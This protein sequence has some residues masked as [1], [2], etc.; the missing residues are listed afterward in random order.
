[1]SLPW[2]EAAFEASIY[3]YFV[4]KSHRVQ[5]SPTH[6]QAQGR[7]DSRAE[8]RKDA[9][10]P[11]SELTEDSLEINGQKHEGSP[12]RDSSCEA[13]LQEM[14]RAMPHLEGMANE[15]QS[16]GEPNTSDRVNSLAVSPP[17]ALIRFRHY[18]SIC[19]EVENLRR[20]NMELHRALQQHQ[21]YAPPPPPPHHHHQHQYHHQ[22]PP[23]PQQPSYYGPSVPAQQQH[24]AGAFHHPHHH[25]GPPSHQHPGARAVT[26]VDAMT[27]HRGRYMPSPVDYRTGGPHHT[28]HKDRTLALSASPS[29][30]R[31]NPP[32][33]PQFRSMDPMDTSQHLDNGSIPGMDGSSNSLNSGKRKSPP[34]MEEQRHHGYG[35]SSARRYMMIRSPP[36]DHPSSLQQQ[37]V[38]S[39][40]GS[41]TASEFAPSPTGDM[42]A[43]AT[44]GAFSEYLQELARFKSTSG[45][46]RVPL[47]SPE[48][49][50]L[51]GR[52]VRQVRRSYKM[53]AKDSRQLLP[54]E[55]ADEV[56][57]HRLSSLRIARLEELGF[58]WQVTPTTVGWNVRY[59]QLV[60]FSKKFGHTNVSRTGEYAQLGEWI[61]S[62]RGLYR[63][64]S[65]ILQGERMT[66]LNAIGFQWKTEKAR[67]GFDEWIVDCERYCSESG[68]LLGK[69]VSYESDNVSHW[70]SLEQNLREWLI[71]Q[72][73]WYIKYSKGDKGYLTDERV[74]RLEDLG[75]V[76]SMKQQS[77]EEA[78]PGC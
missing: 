44:P 32:R 65:R 26:P 46:C 1:M 66:K 53:I 45:N 59:Q 16:A 74:K 49:P 28:S 71:R 60:E 64:K 7:P 48:G 37:V 4:W 78:E 25:H 34:S 3:H 31:R 40:T 42:E 38:A 58:E 52:W 57:P 72:Q 77:E 27:H 23:P 18:P 8:A 35:M 69:L 11:A 33:V 76:W 10:T 24:Y 29:L 63:K 2:D 9:S 51:L 39:E 62:Q 56:T 30:D 68:N 41:T 19:Q 21:A 54:D 20:E 55:T 70:S 47:T 13:I 17:Q 61:H 50:S 5:H 6:S 43:V 12:K 15:S 75:M 36:H 67:K 14:L 22:P 73:S